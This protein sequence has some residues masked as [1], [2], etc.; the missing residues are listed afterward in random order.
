MKVTMKNNLIICKQSNKKH[1]LILIYHVLHIN[2]NF[3]FVILIFFSLF[4]KAFN[5]FFL[6][7]IVS[8]FFGN[9]AFQNGG[10]IPRIL[11][12]GNTAISMI[13]F[14]FQFLVFYFT[15][16]HSV[17]VFRNRVFHIFFISPLFL[18]SYFNDERLFLFLF[19]T[20]TEALC[21]NQQM[22]KIYQLTFKPFN[23]FLYNHRR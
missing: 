8:F 17:F 19:H 1:T 22:K 21:T 23:F 14:L 13:Y 15:F 5:H 16:H 2:L 11:N 7:P 9:N 12:E 6:S 18:F 10:D 4:R 20:I 3:T